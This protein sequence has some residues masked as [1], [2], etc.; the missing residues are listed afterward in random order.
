MRKLEVNDTCPECQ[1]PSGLPHDAWPDDA[2]DC[3]ACGVRLNVCGSVFDDPV[4][5]WV[6]TEA[7]IRDEIM[8]A[9]AK[10]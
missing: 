3:A 7:S 9:R 5:I 4:R 8:Q 2:F 6:R 10:S 1:N